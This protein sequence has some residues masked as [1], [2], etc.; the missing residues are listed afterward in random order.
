MIQR[1]IKWQMHY[2]RYT[3]KLHNEDIDLFLTRWTS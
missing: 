1:Y 3:V 2:I